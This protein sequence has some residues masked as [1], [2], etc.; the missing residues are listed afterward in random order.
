MWWGRVGSCTYCN[1]GWVGGGHIKISTALTSGCGIAC[2]PCTA[3]AWNKWKQSFHRPHIWF[4]WA[5]HFSSNN[6][7]GKQISLKTH[8]S[9]VRGLKSQQ[10]LSSSSVTKPNLGTCHR[11]CCGKRANFLGLLL[12]AILLFQST[13]TVPAHNWMWNK[14]WTFISRY[15]SRDGTKYNYCSHTLTTGRLISSSISLPHHKVAVTNN[16]H[17]SVC[18]LGMLHVMVGQLWPSTTQPAGF[19][20]EYRINIRKKQKEEEFKKGGFANL[21]GR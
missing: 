10:N 4:C 11:V 6:T 18:W 1:Y 21:T 20:N 3:Y 14:S 13:Q 7:L 15:P 2:C 8:Q 16:T 5:A 19:G 9:L 17:E 12:N